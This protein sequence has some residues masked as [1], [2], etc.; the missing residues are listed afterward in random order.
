MDVHPVLMCVLLIV[1]IFVESG[2]V[3]TVNRLTNH[4]GDGR[5]SKSRSAIAVEIELFGTSLCHGFIFGGC[6]VSIGACAVQLDYFVF[7]FLIQT[8]NKRLCIKVFG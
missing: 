5:N 6:S 7:Y 4:F 1:E 2:K 8:V 3:R